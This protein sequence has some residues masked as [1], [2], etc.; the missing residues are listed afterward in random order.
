M[1]PTN[2]KFKSASDGRITLDKDRL[3]SWMQPG[4]PFFLVPLIWK[5]ALSLP[6]GHELEAWYAWRGP[7]HSEDW[8]TTPVDISSGSA[9]S[10]DFYLSQLIYEAKIDVDTRSSRLSCPGLL[11]ALGFRSD[12]YVWLATEPDSVSIWTDFAFQTWFGGLGSE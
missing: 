7:A 8:I 1:L 10:I 3:P 9:A 4:K 11:K 2:A 5:R 12:S 6:A